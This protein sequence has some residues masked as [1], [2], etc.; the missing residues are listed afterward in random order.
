MVA[1]GS[2]E[3][4]G[5]SE[6]RRAHAGYVFCCSGVFVYQ[7]IKYQEGARGSIQGKDK[8]DRE[9]AEG[10]Q[11]AAREAAGD[12]F[13]RSRAEVLQEMERLEDGG[14]DSPDGRAVKR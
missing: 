10:V 5:S 8:V 11:G 7:W 14:A 2:G 1:L 12:S 9:V 3:V 13:S 4:W 6:A